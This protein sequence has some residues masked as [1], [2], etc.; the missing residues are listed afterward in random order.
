MRVGMSREWPAMDFYN[1]RTQVRKGI[2]ERVAM[3]LLARSE[4]HGYE[5]VQA[6]KKLGGLEIRE[7]NIYGVLARL[8]IDGLVRT[9]TLASTAGPP[10][11]YYKL[12][13]SGRQILRRMDEHWHALCD[14]IDQ[15]RSGGSG[16][17][18]S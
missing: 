15:I 13:A 10:R 12:T 9:Y 5:M 6:M 2:L 7:G 1:W 8:Q 18:P 17:G 14:S 16:S 3:N 11:K 4:R